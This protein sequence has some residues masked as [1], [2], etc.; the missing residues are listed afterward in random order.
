MANLAA[1]L[2]LLSHAY[3]QIGYQSLHTVGTHRF[4]APRESYIEK[5]GVF[6]PSF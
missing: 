1:R 5:S 3:V 2:A 6:L 4:K